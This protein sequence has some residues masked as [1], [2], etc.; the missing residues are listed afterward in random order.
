MQPT[1]ALV[2][3]SPDT[4][5]EG[6]ILDSFGTLSSHM[7]QHIVLMNVAVP[8][9]AL[10]APQRL[11]GQWMWRSWPWAT[12]SQVVLLWGWHSPGILPQ[13]AASP[14]LMLTMHVSLIAA[15]A[16]FWLAIVAMPR[17]AGW[18]GIFALLVTGK[19]F[20]LLGA[21]LVFSPNVLFNFV[22]AGHQH[23]AAAAT[24]ALADQ[25][26]AGM[27]MLVACPLTYVGAGIF[28]ASRWFLSLEAD[29]GSHA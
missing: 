7:L 22:A 19:L 26:A 12:A 9:W 23:H 21:L 5:V 28:M 16:W 2:G 14:A 1:G 8:I 29:R 10:F 11:R 13:A 15:S 3:W 4:S 24:A 27:L 17:D 25:Q 18:R 20:C 6:T